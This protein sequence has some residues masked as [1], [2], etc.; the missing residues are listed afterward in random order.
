[1]TDPI[2]LSSATTGTAAPPGGGP[3]RRGLGRGLDALLGVGAMPGI[4]TPVLLDIDPLRIHPNPEQP[5]QHFDS[6]ALNALAES[7]RVHGV[8]HPIIVEPSGDGYQLVAG[9]RRWRA[10]QLAGTATV[11]AIVRPASESARH[12]LEMA[13]TENL[14]RTDLSAI[15][16]AAAYSRLADT[17]GLTHEAIALRV[18]RSRPVVSNTI[19]LLTLPAPIQTA[20]AEGRISAG[21]ARSLLALDNPELQ[22]QLSTRIERDGLSVR[23]VERLVAAAATPTEPVKHRKRPGLSDADESLRRGFEQSLGTPVHLERRGP[24][25]RLVIDFFGDEDLGTLY[26]RLGGRPL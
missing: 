10:S 9:E 15:E 5:R 1:M 6:T 16:E 19:R 2:S 21:H 22:E 23:D 20:L 8:L 25:G 3:R 13:L 12:A 17:F 7:I 18:G 14:V 11:P 26:E 24:G 4:D